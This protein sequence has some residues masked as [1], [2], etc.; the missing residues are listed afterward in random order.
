MAT[1]QGKT[2]NL[3][4]LALMAELT[5]KTIP[6]TG[7]T[8]FRPPFAPVAIGALAGLHRG[9][10]FRPTRLPPTHRLGAGAGRGVR[11]ERAIGC[12]PSGIRGPA[13]PIGSRASTAR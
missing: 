10:A 12:A 13:R 3:S 9:K 8:T 1:D 6:Q 7:T 4:G 5:A 2:S 11:R